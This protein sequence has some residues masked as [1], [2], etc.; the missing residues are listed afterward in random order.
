MKEAF[1]GFRERR[2]PDR[3]KLT[4]MEDLE[5]RGIRIDRDAALKH[6]GAVQDTVRPYRLKAEE[7]RLRTIT[8]TAPVYKPDGAL[9][10]RVNPVEQAKVNVAAAE[11]AERQIVEAPFKLREQAILGNAKA[12]E[13]G[14]TYDP[15]KDIPTGEEALQPQAITAAYIGYVDLLTRVADDGSVTLADPADLP[16]SYPDRPESEY[17]LNWPGGAELSPQ[18]HDNGG[19][20]GDD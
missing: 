11:T 13:Q 15:A 19:R 2:A 5:M 4:G 17:P 1:P 18:G 3:L 8:P 9:T 12:R 10:G 20:E 14:E 6:L 16:L 7:D